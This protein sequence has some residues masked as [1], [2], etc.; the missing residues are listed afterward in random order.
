MSA[1]ITEIKHNLTK[2]DQTFQC[3]LVRHGGDR[4]VISY[5]SDGSYCANDIV[6]VP[7]TLTLAYYQE[8][9]PYI[10]WKMTGPDGRLTG[11]YIH[12]CDCVR[13]RPD[14]V[15]YRDLLLDLWFFPNGSYRLL[16]ED[17]LTDGLARGVIDE[18][19]AAAV[20]QTASDVIARFSSIISALDGEW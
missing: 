5:V 10:V 16:D 3:Q 17:E 6:V 4:I 18:E 12:L 1:T 19:T 9:L 2:P 20:R 8:G 14:A 13:I 11:Y 7:G 15:E